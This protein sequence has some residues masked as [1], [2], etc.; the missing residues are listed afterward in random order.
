MC[1][2]SLLTTLLPIFMGILDQELAA[3]YALM[4]PE[5]SRRGHNNSAYS[6]RVFLG[7]LASGIWQ[8]AVIFY[9]AR[10]VIG[11]GLT[12]SGR[13]LGVWN[14]SLNVY[15]TA[16]LAVHA[17]VIVY[18]ASWTMLSAFLFFVSFCSW[19]V[20][21]P[22]LT[23]KG[24]SITAGL[25]PSLFWGV[26]L[27]YQ[28]P[29]S[30]LYTA[31]AVAI[32]V[33]PILSYDAVKRA[34]FP[35]FKHLVQEL[36]CRGLVGDME[37]IVSAADGEMQR[38]RL[39][40]YLG[41]VDPGSCYAGHGDVPL[42]AGAAADYTT[43]VDTPRTS[44]LS[45]VER[46]ASRVGHAVTPRQSGAS[47]PGGAAV[48]GLGR[49]DE[50]DSFSYIGVGGVDPPAAAPAGD[51][52]HTPGRR[53]GGGGT[54]HLM[55]RKGPLRF[56]GFN[57]DGD[58][59]SSRAGL[60]LA[61]LLAHSEA[62]ADRWRLR[63]ARMRHLRRA[64]SDAQPDVGGVRSS[65]L[66]PATRR[67]HHNSRTAGAG[68]GAAFGAPPSAAE[69][70]G[71]GGPVSLR[72]RPHVGSSALSRSLSDSRIVGDSV[73]NRLISISDGDGCGLRSPR[74]ARRADLARLTEWARLMRANRG[75]GRGGGGGA[76]SANWADAATAAGD[77]DTSFEAVVE[78]DTLLGDDTRG[79][80]VLPSVV[81]GGG[82]GAVRRGGRP[83]ALSIQRRLTLVWTQIQASY[84][85]DK[86]PQECLANEHAVFLSET[87][88]K[89]GPQ[90]RGRACTDT[91]RREPAAEDRRG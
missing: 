9:F 7:W 32:C 2:L 10:S 62:E 34:W 47:A 65:L 19:F 13:N 29:A 49:L 35:N 28:Q 3:P 46:R 59:H 83:W 88:V 1:N 68:G 45:D 26:Q 82:G 43:S 41:I 86:Q 16:V 71:D 77:P 70:A 11:D 5:V 58:L 18:V 20:I 90:G 42:K 40:S 89:T 61:P 48:D 84:W 52:S 76:H 6:F 69:A 8:S 21:G 55:R 63:R 78:V 30:W 79:M 27:M 36:Q 53:A 39:L 33:L 24:P 51:G 14:L 66:T 67:S 74:S 31:M 38:D 22:L 73:V 25:S 54:L 81:G 75:G 80:H 50:T 85:S 60:H 12:A 15:S 17:M 23:T 87:S 44:M 72:F 4:F 91:P 56:T 64:W 37:T 57:I